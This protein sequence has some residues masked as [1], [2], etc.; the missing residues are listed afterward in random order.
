M[1]IV[2]KLSQTESLADW[3]GAQLSAMWVEAD[4]VFKQ[5]ALVPVKL[6]DAA[7]RAKH[8]AE[9]LAALIIRSR[10]EFEWWMRDVNRVELIPMGTNPI[11]VS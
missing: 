2:E 7:A 9:R 10:V 4:R 11:V 3:D 8:D 6:P 1:P 5:L